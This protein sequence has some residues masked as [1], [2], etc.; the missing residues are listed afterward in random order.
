MIYE[1]HSRGLVEKNKRSKSL[2]FNFSLEYSIVLL[3]RVEIEAIFFFE[4]AYMLKVCNFELGNGEI[5]N[6]NE[7]GVVF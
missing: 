4:I 3:L 2:F 5:N 1:S 6:F 7:N